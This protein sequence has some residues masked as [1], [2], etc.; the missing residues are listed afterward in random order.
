MDGGSTDGEGEALV[1]HTVTMDLTDEQLDESVVH[2]IMHTIETS[3][4]TPRAVIVGGKQL[5]D[6]DATLRQAGF[7]NTTDID[8]VFP[9]SAF[10]DGSEGETEEIDVE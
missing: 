9:A 8:V 10:P 2:D 3:M 7:S 6:L 4:G 1:M 5:T